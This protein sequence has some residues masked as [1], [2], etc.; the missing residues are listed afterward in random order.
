MFDIND[1]AT[2]TLFDQVNFT[3]SSRVNFNTILSDFVSNYPVFHYQGSFTT[4]DCG[5]IVNWYV[6][7]KKFPIT[8]AQLNALETN[9]TKIDAPNNR[10]IQNLNG[11]T[12][13]L[14]SPGCN[15]DLPTVRYSLA[16]WETR[17][18]IMALLGIVMAV[19]GL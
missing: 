12:V 17:L 11:R 9:T 2:N 14:I 7:Q 4:P 19:L 3:V 15:I 13:R 5:E 8:T 16:K 1:T 6:I 18:F 10:N